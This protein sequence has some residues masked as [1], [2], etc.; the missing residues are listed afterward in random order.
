MRIPPLS[1]L[2]I[3]LV[4]QGRSITDGLAA[5]TAA[6]KRADELGFRRM[7]VAE[8]HAA[9]AVG[10]IA[11]PV[12]A[13][14]L[15]GQ[16]SRLRVGSGGVLVPNHAPLVVAEQFATLAA[17]H[18]DRI[19]LGLGRGPGTMDPAIVRSLRRG[20]EPTT[21]E[22]YRDDIVELLG[23]LSGERGVTLLPGA[24]DVPA[25]QPWLLSSSTAGAEL[26]AELGLPI[27]FAHHIRPENTVEAIERYREKFQP[28]RWQQQPYVM[29]CVETVCADTE[30]EATRLAQAINVLKVGLLSNRADVRLPT[31]EQAATVEFD[32]AVT[33]ALARRNDQQA[34]GSPATV[35][36]RLVDLTERTGA[37]ELMLASVIFDVEA[38]IR[39]FEL[40]VE[41]V[42]AGPVR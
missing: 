6:T 2:E 36:S 18:P 40:V 26:A 9:A 37:D 13:T 27:A 31:P 28:S 34:M 7:W 42:A 38:R 8:H 39:S 21:D 25:P 23:Y 12:L 22:Q 14:H 32:P 1:G 35:R 33:Q 20:G 41:A 16:T 17:L 15:A 10:S 29:I 24:Q 19:D 11:P 3:A 4:E 30:A 5:V